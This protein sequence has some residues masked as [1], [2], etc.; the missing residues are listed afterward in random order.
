MSCRSSDE[1]SGNGKT[2]LGRPE[3]SPNGCV[4]CR[5][6]P[7]NASRSKPSDSEQAWLAVT[8]DWEHGV[9]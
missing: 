5:A 8:V 7:G 4:L 6:H 3:R 2:L 9:H 1:V